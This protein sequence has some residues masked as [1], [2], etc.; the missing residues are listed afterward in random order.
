MNRLIISGRRIDGFLLDLD[1]ALLDGSVIRQD[2]QRF[3]STLKK[4]R[5]PFVC[6]SNRSSDDRESIC[7]M[8]NTYTHLV[9]PQDI[10]TPIEATPMYL[11]QHYTGYVRD[12]FG[13]DAFVNTLRE[14]GLSAD[15]LIGDQNQNSCELFLLGNIPQFTSSDIERIYQS[16]MQTASVSAQHRR[17]V[18]LASNPDIGH[19]GEG[20]IFVSDTGSLVKAISERLDIEV[21][22]IGKPGPTLFQLGISQI[23]V[24][25]SRIAMI[26]DNPETDVVGAKENGIF[27]IL[28]VPNE[29]NSEN[30]TDALQPDAICYDYCALLESLA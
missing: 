24:H 22:Y 27:S 8:L 10:L 12:V 29:F 11:E 17:Q 26:G 18:L 6:V 30:R 4:N 14:A 21:D 7:S 9:E 23:G 13:T 5:I 19:P 2:A 3:L 1:G 28:Y 16:I 15:T 25:P 20:G